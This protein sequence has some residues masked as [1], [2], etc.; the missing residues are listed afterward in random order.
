MSKAA[1]TWKAPRLRT[2]LS[3]LSLLALLQFCLAAAHFW[4][5]ANVQSNAFRFPLPHRVAKMVTAF[6]TTPAQHHAAMLA[7][8]RS[9][10]TNIWL[11][12]SAISLQELR[13]MR[14]VP[15]V[16]AL[17]Q[18]YLQD[19]GKREVLAWI[20]MDQALTEAIPQSEALRLWTAHPLRL[21][22]QLRGSHWL[23]L[24][25]RHRLAERIYGIPPG[26]ISALLSLVVAASAL[27]MLW[28]GLGPLER[29]AHR[30]GQFA[31]DPK[32]QA[33]AVKGP[34]ET[35]AITAAVNQMQIDIDRLLQDR[36][37][38]LGAMSHD[39]RT[40]LTRLRLRV[41][42]FTDTGAREKA[43]ADIE[44]MSAIVEDA[45]S[46]A[47]LGTQ[48]IQLQRIAALDWL[49]ESV[50]AWSSAL[51]I[52]AQA[53][54]QHVYIACDPRMLA[55]ALCNLLANAERHAREVSVHISASAEHV[56]IDVLDRGPGIPASEKLRVRQSYQRG[57]QA[58]SMDKAG[59]GLGLTI[60][61]AIVEQH[62]GTLS[63]L[64]REG[65]GLVAR[66]RLPA[67]TEPQA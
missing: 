9:E 48:D 3:L 17:L 32:P 44:A 26:F 51:G 29:L 46:Y 66:M 10:E 65:G 40:Y 50:R 33:L 45:L 11:S 55:R 34:R 37:A 35:R 53:S 24:E 18:R 2:L 6:E 25:T 28:R 42:L 21:A 19:Q 4:Q 38:M 39:L 36:Q 16:A 13:G 64:D 56:E 41:E 58:R 67:S 49:Q 14:A 60:A 22:V 5:A 63:L 27:L 61:I 8:L 15:Q 47:R 59:S 31:K 1:R 43:A 12:D 62:G 7:A 23:M 20:A 30:L 52:Q 54:M 57:D